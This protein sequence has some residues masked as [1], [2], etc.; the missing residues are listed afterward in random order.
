MVGRTLA[1]YEILDTLGQG[2]MGVVYKARDRQLDRFVAIKVLTA[3]VANPERQKRFVQEARA[4][5]GLNHPNIITVYDIGNENGVDFIVME[6]VA[7]RTLDK[8]IPRAGMKPVDLL[9]YAIPICDALARA[10]AAGIV[11]RDLKPGNVMIGDDGQVKLL[12]FGLAKLS[13]LHGASDEELTRP[14]SSRTEEGSIIGTVCYMSPEQVEARKV[15]ARSDIFSF[16]ALLYEMATG[17]RA[18]LGRSKISTLAAILSSDPAKPTEFQPDLPRE[19]VKIIQRCLRKDPAWRYQ[20]AADLKISLHDLLKDLESGV[21]ETPRSAPA[22]RLAF[23]WYAA[24]ALGLIAG[25]AGAWWWASRAAERTSQRTVRPLTTYSGNEYEPALSPNGSQFA[26][27][28][29]GQGRD[30]LDI[31]VR[32]VEGGSALR[33][34]TNPAPDHSPAWSPDGQSLAFVRGNAI[35]VIPALGGAERR[36]VQFP[37]GTIYVDQAYP[38]RLDWSP[39][40]HFLAFNGSEDDSPQTI[41]IV[42]TDSG[43]YHRA[44]KPPKGFHSERS[45]AFSPDGRTLAWVRARDTNSRAVI[46]ARINGDGSPSGE[47]REI[48]G[49]RDR[50]EDLAWEPDGRGLILSVRVGGERSGLFRMRLNGTLEPLGFDSAIARWASLSRTGNRMAFEKRRRDANIY[51]MDGPGPDGGPRPYEECRVHP[52][53]DSTAQDRAAMISPDGRRIVFDSDRGEYNEVH[54]ATIDGANQTALTNMGPTAQ[55]KSAVVPKREHD[56]IRP[57]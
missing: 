45:P 46:F 44:S 30:N 23:P 8:V 41:W 1:H 27:T 57:V 20:S 42:S 18:F 16:G 6:L 22:R 24:L 7:G 50:I 4:A 38:G 10:H 11:H 5:S 48:T 54:I 25:A 13:D 12:D 15:D 43:E 39:D 26:F 47:E 34:T 17:H 28:W 19:L 49:Y 53:V 36:L 40:G 52:V 2:G 37:R 29:N 9:R 56:R 3:E 51:R 31:Y 55:G 32:L 14:M 21:V 35:Y 33:L